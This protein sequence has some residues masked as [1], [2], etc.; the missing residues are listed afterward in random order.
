MVCTLAEH[1]SV[2]RVGRPPWSGPKHYD[3]FGTPFVE[4]MG[5]AVPLLLGRS[6]QQLNALKRKEIILLKVP[7]NKANI[8]I[9]SPPRYR[10]V[11]APNTGRFE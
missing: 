11:R 4:R 10:V 3:D 2:H 1:R 8:I 6:V 9:D 5:D 7:N